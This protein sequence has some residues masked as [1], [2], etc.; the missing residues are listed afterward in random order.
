[1][2]M[3]QVVSRSPA[4]PG[5]ALESKLLRNSHSRWEVAVAGFVALFAVDTLDRYMHAPETMFALR[6]IAGVLGG[7][8]VLCTYSTFRTGLAEGFWVAKAL[9]I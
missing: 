2:A 9:A 3:G 6:L 1:M 5:W 4:S 8:V 7:L